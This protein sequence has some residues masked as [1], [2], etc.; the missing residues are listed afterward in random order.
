MPEPGAPS[1]IALAIIWLL[2]G[3][4]MVLITVWLGWTR[5]ASVL[6]GHPVTLVAAIA[7]GLIGFIATAWSIATL[8]LGGRQDR[9]GDPQHP[10]RRTP[11]QLRRRAKVR[12]I[13]AVP[14]LIVCA[15]L[16]AALA[17]ARPLPASAV[18][19]AAMHTQDNVQVVERLSWYEMRPTREDKTGHTITPTVGLVFSPGAR[20]DPRAYAN[21]LR[22]LARAGYLVIVLK[23]PFGLAL[24][25]SNHAATVIKLHPEIEHWAV[26]GHSLGGVAAA[27]YADEH[28]E[29]AGLVFFGSYPASTL[30][31]TDLKVL[32]ISGSADGLSTPAD[33]EANKAKLPPTTTYLVVEGAVHS[34][35]GDYGDQPGDGLPTGDRVA[36]QAQITTATQKLL[37]SLMPPPPP[38]KK[39]K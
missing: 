7:C 36:A 28:S 6:S 17:Y 9:E 2:L 3:L 26:G 31:R 13:L 32:S 5:W 14:A 12:I 27:T 25:D 19:V 11:E 38:R 4:T 34:W 10:A 39:K 35:F 16:V 30:T 1:R 20:V 33:I 8:I 29:V 37:A 21:I 22:P 15:A 23:E 24:L 18:A